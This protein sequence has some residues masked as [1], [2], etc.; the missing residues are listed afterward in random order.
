MHGGPV[1]KD[2]PPGAKV[3]VDL[4]FDGQGLR[5]D[6][7]VAFDCKPIFQRSLLQVLAAGES[8]AAAADVNGKVAVGGH[9]W[10]SIGQPFGESR[11]DTWPT[12]E[13]A[14]ILRHDQVFHRHWSAQQF[15]RICH[16]KLAD[17]LHKIP[18]QYRKGR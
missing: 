14:E 7:P 18:G 11:G 3:K 12:M 5:A 6:D 13:V 2:Q 1:R 8:K 10:A 17:D 9:G 4:L 15:D 16:P